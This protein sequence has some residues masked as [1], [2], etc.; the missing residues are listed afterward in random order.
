MVHDIRPAH[1]VSYPMYRDGTHRRTRKTR[2][3]IL[4][5][6]RS[7]WF[8]R[9]L[10]RLTQKMEQIDQRRQGLGDQMNIPRLLKLMR[11]E[12]RVGPVVGVTSQ[13]E[14]LGERLANLTR[15]HTASRGDLWNSPRL[16]LSGLRLCG[17]NPGESSVNQVDSV[18]SFQETIVT[19]WGPT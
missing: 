9:T 13:S 16:G 14:R 3:P 11:P 15:H 12:T 2:S 5:Y 17:Q 8:C 6:H 7:Q 1:P 19:E 4:L 10:S 18:T